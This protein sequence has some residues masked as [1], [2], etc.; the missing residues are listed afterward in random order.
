MSSRSFRRSSGPM[1]RAGCAMASQERGATMVMTGP[2]GRETRTVEAKKPR[3]R[4]VGRNAELH[5]IV[6]TL[7]AGSSVLLSGGHGMGKTFLADAVDRTLRGSGVQALRVRGTAAGAGHPLHALKAAIGLGHTSITEQAVIV[8]ATK[9][10]NRGR[11]AADRTPVVIVD[12]IQLLDAESADWLARL[13]YAR[14]VALLA[15][16]SPHPRGTRSELISEA[17]TLANSLWKIGR[18][19]V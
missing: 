4:V 19:H 18:A 2:D 5:S 12:D 17:M 11:G 15:T 9:V 8:E 16:L 10:L 13:V 6:D 1:R 3:G 7:L 14:R